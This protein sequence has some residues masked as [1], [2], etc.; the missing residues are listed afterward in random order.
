M[1]SFNDVLYMNVLIP[2]ARGY[3]VVVPEPA[4]VSVSNFFN[5]LLFP[6]RF[7]NA[8]LQG[9][10]TKSADELF[11][12][13]INSTVGVAGLF[14]VANAHLGIRSH[15]ED[16]G[17][18][19]GVYG[20][21]SGFH[22]VLPVLGPSNVRDVFGRTG[23]SF[24]NPVSYVENSRDSIALKAYNQLNALSLRPGEYEAMRNDA[25]DLYPFLRDLYEKRRNAMI[26]E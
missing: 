24:V 20:L 10:T 16:L 15:D 7:I 26:K 14:D 5:N 9:E 3:A 12:F 25:I 17:Q 6:V 23:D 18:T 2:A 13:V 8:L 22:I 21:G 1:T 4:R 19:L 11:R